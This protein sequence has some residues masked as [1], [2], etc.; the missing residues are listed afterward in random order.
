MND[1][2]KVDKLFQCVRELKVGM[3]SLHNTGSL[4]GMPDARSNEAYMQRAKEHG[5]VNEQGELLDF[6][7]RE[8]IADELEHMVSKG[9]GGNFTVYN[10]IPCYYAFNPRRGYTEKTPAVRVKRIVEELVHPLYP[11]VDVNDVIA[12]IE[13]WTVSP[14]HCLNPM[15]D[16][17]NQH[18]A[19][20]QLEMAELIDA[21]VAALAVKLNVDNKAVKLTETSYRRN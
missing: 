19:G 13:A 8:V 7:T 21:Q 16:T 6:Y 4:R 5:L 10:C 9:Q 3:L 15:F 2:I 20:A 18:V 1:K 14:E 12:R 11:L 17:V